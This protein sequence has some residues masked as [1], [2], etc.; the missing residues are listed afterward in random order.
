MILAVAAAASPAKRR[1]SRRAG[2]AILT[3]SAIAVATFAVPEWDR[4][5]LTSGVYKYSRGLEPDDLEARLRAGNLEYYK[6]GAAGTVSVRRLAGTS[7]LA[8]DGKVDASDAGDMLTQRLLGLLPTLLHPDPQDALVIGLGSGVTVDAV[9]ASGEVQRTDVVEISPEVI[10]A[11]A[12]FEHKNRGVLKRPGLRLLVGDGRSHLR[13]SPRKYDVIVSEPSNPWMAGVAALFTRE[14]FEAARA[15]LRPGGVF[16]QWAHTYEIAEE[17]LRSIVRTFS[18]VFPD[19]TMWL[20][21]DADLLLIG[22]P[23]RGIDSRLAALPERLGKGHVPAMLDDIAVTRDAAAFMLFSM[24]A[25]GPVELASY[26]GGGR[27]ADR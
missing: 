9:F 16:C 15:R 1:S 6:E 12:Y 3:G 10:E 27:A 4:D 5:L 26:G 8:I 23:D 11:S 19:G 17:D 14:F 18:S 20:V 2:I 13:L 25:G 7:S 21:G 22:L 24:F